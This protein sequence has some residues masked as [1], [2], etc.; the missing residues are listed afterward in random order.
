MSDDLVEEGLV[1]FGPHIRGRNCGSCKACCTSV[2]VD[3]SPTEHKDANVRCKHVCSKGCAIYPQRP[4]P[5]QVWSCRW[6]FDQGTAG[7][8]RPDHSGYVIDCAPD[9][10]DAEAA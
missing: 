1:V 10:D 9:T 6:L 8:R 4:R 7:L 3:L 2:P 5:C